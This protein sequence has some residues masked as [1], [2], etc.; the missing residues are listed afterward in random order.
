MAER[1]EAEQNCRLGQFCVSADKLI[2]SA[3]NPLPSEVGESL[4]RI[5]HAVHVEL[6]LNCAASIIKSV[7]KFFGKF[8]FH[9]LTLSVTC[10]FNH[11]ADSEGSF[12][13]RTNFDRYLIVGTTDTSGFQ[14]HIWT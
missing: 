13:F 1:A 14:F 11:P 10:S 4:V 6:L 5:G 7:Q 2:Q 3:D 12:S 8:F 9:G